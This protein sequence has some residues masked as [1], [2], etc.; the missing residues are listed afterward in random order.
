MVVVV[1]RSVAVGHFSHTEGCPAPVEE[2]HPRC[3]SRADGT[4]N[5]LDSLAEISSFLRLFNRLKSH[6]AA[7]VVDA[8]QHRPSA[9]RGEGS[10]LSS[11]TVRLTRKRN[12][13]LDELTLASS[14]RILEQLAEFSR[15]AIVIRLHLRLPLNKLLDGYQGEAVYSVRADR[16]AR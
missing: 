9:A 5:P 11:K 8:E 3:H 6:Y 14:Q 1:D 10:D 15:I 4:R 2:R 7:S 12:F 16:R 13:E